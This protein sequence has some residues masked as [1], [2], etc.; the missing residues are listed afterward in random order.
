MMDLEEMLTHWIFL[1][2]IEMLVER[3][4]THLIGSWQV[5]CS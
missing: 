4:T 1:M 3:V 2:M 5:T